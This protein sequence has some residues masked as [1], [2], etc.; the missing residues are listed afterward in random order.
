MI[1][2]RLWVA[3]S[4]TAA[5]YLLGLGLGKQIYYFGAALMTLVILLALLAAATLKATMRCEIFFREKEVLRGEKV[6]MGVDISQR[7]PFPARTKQ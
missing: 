6:H 2:R 5:L 7:C 4:F 1:T 3:L